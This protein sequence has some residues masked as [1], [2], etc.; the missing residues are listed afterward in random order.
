[1]LENTCCKT[2][3]FLTDECGKIILDPLKPGAIHYEEISC[4]ENRPRKCVKLPSGETVTMEEVTI[5]ISGFIAVD[6]HGGKRSS[7]VP[8]CTIKQLLLCA[9]KGTKITF[10]AKSFHCFSAPVAKGDKI[11]VFIAIGTVVEAEANVKIVVSAGECPVPAAETVRFI[12]ASSAV[13]KNTCI[14]TRKIYDSVFFKSDICFVIEKEEEKKC[15]VIEKITGRIFQP[16]DGISKVYY[17][18]VDMK[19]AALIQIENKSACCMEAT[20]ELSDDRKIIQTI[21]RDQQVTMDVGAIQRLLIQ[22]RGNSESYCRGFYSLCL[23][24]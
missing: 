5:T 14:H 10:T 16:C 9:P 23:R 4:P 3:C 20:V 21:D 2:A 1:M 15:P 8:F 11:K 24:H 12:P 6:H 7:P 13:K 22:C 17:K 19:P 18:A